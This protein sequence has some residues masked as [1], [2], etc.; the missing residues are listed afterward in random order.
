MKVSVIIPVFNEENYID[1]C[2]E[3]LQN[4][5]EKPDEVIVVDNNCTDE[6]VKIAKKF[7][8]KIIKEKRQGIIF[9]RNRGFNAARFEIIA[10]CDADTILPKTWIRKIKENFSQRKIAGIT[11]PVFFYDLNIPTLFLVKGYLKAMKFFQKGKNTLLGPNL[12]ISKK[13]WVKIKNKVCFDDKKVHE[14][15][16]LALHIYQAGGEILVDENLV[17]KASGRRIIKNPF[18]FFIEYPIR[19]IKTL[20]VH[21]I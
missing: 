15:I 3:S 14:D 21:T 4:Q 11:G 13:I 12:A 16:D 7:P 1:K 9:S 5:E 2:L 20:L 18:S 17:I 10:R 8:V 6:T 19:L